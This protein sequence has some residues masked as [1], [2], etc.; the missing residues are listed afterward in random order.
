ML[1]RRTNLLLDE[2]TYQSLFILS[3]EK[4]ISVGEIIREALKEKYSG[5]DAVKIKRRMEAV[6]AI[7]DLW[8]KTMRRGKKTDY[9]AL[10]EYGRRF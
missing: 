7:M 8:K 4:G 3:K 9:K 2:G 6:K 5:K 10:I 1:N